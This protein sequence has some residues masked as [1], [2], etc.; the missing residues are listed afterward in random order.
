MFVNFVIS[1]LMKA[2]LALY[3][4]QSDDSATP[5]W[6]PIVIVAILV[7]IFFAAIF[8]SSGIRE[9]EDE[10]AEE[11]TVDHDEP[12]PE[13]ESETEL[14]PPTPPKPDDLKKIEGIGPKI[15]SVL[16]EANIITFAQLAATSV[17]D[18]ERIVREEAGIRVAF[19]D[20]W[21]EQA[22]MAADGDWDGLKLYQDALQGGRVA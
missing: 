21:P 4:A 14:E 3:L 6:V 5:A 15:Q 10:E 19:P 13:P 18:L 12:E 7:L 20:T 1:L 22:K 16:A 8:S 11:T 2:P 17:A 9:G